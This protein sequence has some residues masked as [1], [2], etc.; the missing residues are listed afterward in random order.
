MI[1]TTTIRWI[2]LGF[3][4]SLCGSSSLAILKLAKQVGEYLGVSAGE[5]FLGR[6]NGRQTGKRE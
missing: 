2:P 3:W 6:I 4:P 5:A 1:L